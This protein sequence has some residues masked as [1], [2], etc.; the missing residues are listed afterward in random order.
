MH[1]DKSSGFRPVAQTWYAD[2]I[3]LF[4]PVQQKVGAFLASIPEFPFQEGANLNA[5]NINYMTLKA[6]G[7]LK[8]LQDLEAQGFPWN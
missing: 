6:A 3:W 2:N 5:G 4:V 7:V 8:K 1:D